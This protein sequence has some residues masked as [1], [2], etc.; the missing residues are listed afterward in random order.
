MVCGRRAGAGTGLL[1]GAR[2]KVGGRLLNRVIRE[3]N[4]SVAI[5]HGFL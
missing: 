3:F 4:L 1:E 5:F 2:R